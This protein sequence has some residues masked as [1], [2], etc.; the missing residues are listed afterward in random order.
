MADYKLMESGQ[1]TQN[2]K[3]LAVVTRLL[4]YKGH[5]GK[6]IQRIEQI[7]LKVGSWEER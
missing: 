7:G 5:P 4:F 2:I 3:M 6:A 1:I